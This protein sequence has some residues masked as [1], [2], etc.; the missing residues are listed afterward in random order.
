[1]FDVECFGATIFFVALYRKNFCVLR[2]QVASV[3]TLDN[4]IEIENSFMLVFEQKDQYHAHRS[5]E[6]NLGSLEGN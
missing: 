6:Y 3:L 1:M 2:F 5:S 4:V